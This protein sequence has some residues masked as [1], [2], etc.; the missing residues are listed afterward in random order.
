M[1]AQCQVRSNTERPCLRFAEVEIRGVSFCGA[2]AREQESYFA[3]GE[4]VALEEKQGLRSKQLAEALKR[5][6]RERM[7]G[8][9]RIAA[10][11]HRGTSGV[12]ESKPLALSNS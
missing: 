6:R 7:V 11:A 5:M 2:C 1:P 12:Y 8:T 10:E 9:E 3:I 4:L